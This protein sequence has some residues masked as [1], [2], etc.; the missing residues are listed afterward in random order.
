MS[1]ARVE[2]LQQRWRSMGALSA[3]EATLEA[4]GFSDHYVD[5]LAKSTVDRKPKVIKD[6]TW[7]MIEVDASC[8]LLLDSPLLQR[9]R[10]VR[11]LGFSYL[12]YPSAEHTRFVHSLGM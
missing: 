3:L 1:I 12:T 8:L 4:I 7:G 2:D 9:M 11:Q 10:G 6:S 5:Q